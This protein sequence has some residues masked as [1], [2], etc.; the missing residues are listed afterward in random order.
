MS[1]KTVLWLVGTTL[2]GAMYVAAS[3]FVGGDRRLLL[4]GNT[5]DA[6]RQFELSCETCHA[7]PP[8]ADAQ[9][10]GKALNQTC[11]ACHDDDLEAANDSHPSSTF[12]TPRMADYWNRLD[13]RLCT[14]CHREHRPEISLPGAVTVASDFC[15]ACHS[16]GDQDVRRVRPSHAGLTF[17]SCASAG[18]HNYHDNRALYE[19]FLAGHAAM[20]ALAPKPVH[21]LTARSRTLQRATVA[22]LAREDA[23]APAAV[24][25]DDAVLLK[26]SASGHAAADVNCDACHAANLP[27]GATPEDVAAHWVTV[28]STVACTSC[29]KPQA[30][31]FAKGRH[32]MRRHPRIAKPRDPRDSLE[33]LGFSGVMLGAIADWLSTPPVPARMTVGE[34]RLPMRPDVPAHRAIDCGTCHEPHGVNTGQAAVEACASCHDGDHTRA[35]FDSPHHRL[36]QAERAG[37]APPGTG[38]SCATCHMPMTEVR[39]TVVANHNQNDNL[40]PN[41]KMVRPVCLDCHGL[42]FSL[43]ALADAKLIERNFT[44]RPAVHV[45]SPEWAARRF[46]EAED[47]T[48]AP[49]R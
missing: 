46:I 20:P 8:F 43:N 47:D 7:A 3:A 4:V 31:S 25:T 9:A 19:D 38:V 42:S 40:R 49:S 14:N 26:W 10:S 35:Y 5:T 36:W 17:D 18:C 33:D 44:G 41:E 29:H 37:R 2:I 28:P 34:A 27:A 30:R 16:E 6:H 32:G 48:S 23:L 11:R 1:S 24:L 45:E 22:P 15:V 12:R 21:A 13:A 39:G